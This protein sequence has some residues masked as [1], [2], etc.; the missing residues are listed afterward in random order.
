MSIA[1]RALAAHEADEEATRLRKEA[2]QIERRAKAFAAISRRA[3]DFG[4]SVTEADIVGDRYDGD[5]RYSAWIPVDDDVSLEFIWEI[6]WTGAKDVLT[7]VRGRVADQLYWN[8]PPGEFEKGPGGGVYGCYSLSM[9]EINDLVGLGRYIKQVR[10]ARDAWRR[11]HG[12]EA[13]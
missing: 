12:V 11:K 10:S 8:L 7:T 2:Q 6:P 9:P 4:L 3:E 13:D 1:D 5:R